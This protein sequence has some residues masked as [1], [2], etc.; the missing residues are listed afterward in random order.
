[1]VIYVISM[2]TKIVRRV[3]LVARVIVVIQDVVGAALFE[4]HGT[5]VVGL[6]QHVGIFDGGCVMKGIDRKSVV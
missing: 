3:R 1:M 6:G 5:Q 4:R 2:R